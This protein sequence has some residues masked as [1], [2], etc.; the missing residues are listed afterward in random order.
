MKPLTAPLML[1]FTA[2][3]WRLIELRHATASAQNPCQL[4]QQ[5]PSKFKI[6]DYLAS[7][8]KCQIID[9][10]LYSGKHVVLGIVLS[11]G[12]ANVNQ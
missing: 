9:Y 8:K 11:L 5:T 4:L 1:L 12:S 7:E 3:R 6:D 2:Q 10:Y